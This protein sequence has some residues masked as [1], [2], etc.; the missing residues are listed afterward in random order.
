M[1]VVEQIRL[2]DNSTP[3]VVLGCFRHG[4]LG[5]VRSLGRLGV[6]VYA[7]D[8]DRHTPA[9]FSK[10]CRE[11]LVW[12]LHAAAPEASVRFLRELAD[13]IGR[14]AVLIPTSD[15]GAM[16][17]LDLATQ[18][19]DRFVFPRP[20]PALVR[21]LC[22]KR[23]M[24]RLAREHDVPAPETR[25]PQSRAEVIE[26]LDIA[27]FPVLLKPIYSLRPGRPPQTMEIVHSASQLLDRY[28]AIEDPAEPNL[29]LQEYIPGPDEATWTFNG[30]FGRNSACLVSFSGRKLRNHA[31]YF[32]QCCLGKC[33]QNDIVEQTTIRF[34]RELGY[35]GAL[36]LGYRYDAR[37]GRYK[38]NDVNPRVGA[39]FRVFV[40][41]NG[42][43][44]ARALY[45][46]LTGQPVAA[47]RPREGR[48][49]ILEDGDL[50][51]SIRYWRDGNL[52]LRQWRESLRG[53]AEGTYLDRDDPLPAL[54]V[55]V[56]RPAR[57]LW[58]GLRGAIGAA[59][60]PAAAAAGGA[61]RRA[62]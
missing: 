49:W 53:I 41:E 37:D 18:L 52:S 20:D 59:A 31:P 1:A 14:P 5:I 3:A 21:A 51:S 35:Q 38:I 33:Q 32:G 6:P 28:D 25:F 27:R 50:K 15:V 8:A 46:D 4:G 29:M 26:Y 17:V 42:I 55:G 34:M 36:D 40:G 30:Y 44:V 58:R 11:R 60:A 13:R 39:M 24:Y 9:F 57:K 43:D 12:D 23:E 47:A 22:S 2:E 48:K 7:I 10:Y 45:Q 61:A 62:P 56:V 19:E 16:F 54:C